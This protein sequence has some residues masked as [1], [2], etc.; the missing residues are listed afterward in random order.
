MS[1]VNDEWELDV[2]LLLEGVDRGECAGSQDYGPGLEQFTE[3]NRRAETQ[4]V[5]VVLPHSLR[6]WL[7]T[8]Q[9]APL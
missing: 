7:V 8:E 1:A 2:Q 5:Q 3:H 6:V 9:P 4:Y